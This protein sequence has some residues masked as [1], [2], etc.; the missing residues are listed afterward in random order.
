MVQLLTLAP[1]NASNFINMCEKLKYEDVPRV[2]E[3]FLYLHGCLLRYKL[4][5]IKI[6]WARSSRIGEALFIQ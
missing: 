3:S 4:I 1:E 6:K 2:L 5:L